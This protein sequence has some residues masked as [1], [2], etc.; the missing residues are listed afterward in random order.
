MDTLFELL[1]NQCVDASTLQLNYRPLPPE[2]I[3]SGQPE[4]GTLELGQLSRCSIGVWEISP[5]I[6]TDV[7]VDE[8]F[9]VLHGRATVIFSDGSPPLELKA[10]SVGRFS[11]GAATTWAVTETL[12]KIYIA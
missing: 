11:V 10:G 3:I 7:E 12:R 8:I 5:S 9:V 4:V 1:A 2:Q 6:T